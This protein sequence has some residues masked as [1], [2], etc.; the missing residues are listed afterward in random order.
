MGS[1]AA[2]QVGVW[3]HNAAV[4][5]ERGV[6]AVARVLLARGF[7]VSGSD[8]RE[9]QITRALRNEGATVTIGHSAVVHACKICEKLEPPQMLARSKMPSLSSMQFTSSSLGRRWHMSMAM[10]RHS[11]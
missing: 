5:R 8:V 10:R 3:E 4:H 6:S 11:R 7:N 9:S 1:L 2:G